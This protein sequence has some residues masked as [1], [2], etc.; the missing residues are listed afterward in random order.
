[1]SNFQGCSEVHRGV[2]GE[3]AQS[4][5]GAGRCSACL[6]ESRTPPVQHPAASHTPVLP[7]SAA[8]LLFSNK[9]SSKKEH[10]YMREKEEWYF[11]SVLA[12]QG[13]GTKRRPICYSSS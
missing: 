6:G 5:C 4:L 7:F 11:C 8:N 10:K 9:I 3:D 12:F 13:A 2:T 1:M